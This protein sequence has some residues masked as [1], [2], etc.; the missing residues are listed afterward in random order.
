MPVSPR[1]FAVFGHFQNLNLL[2]LLEDLRTGRTV[3]RAWRAGSRLCPV[4]HGL[5][6]GEV[7][8]DLDELG[9]VTDLGF[10]CD[11]AARRLGAE[12]AAVVDF[13]RAWD[14]DDLTDGS[15]VRQLAELWAERLADAEVVQELLTDRPAVAEPVAIR[16]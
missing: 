7:V 8:H 5:P 12:Q 1:I 6:R 13:V 16:D 2:A 11:F 14:E 4:A 3:R 15:L 9:Q 10:G